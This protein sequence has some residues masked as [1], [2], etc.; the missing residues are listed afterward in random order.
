MECIGCGS[1]IPEKRT[2][3]HARFCSNHCRELTDRA[4]YQKKN[5][6]KTEV[7][8]G[9]RGAM[10]ELLVCA[11]LMGLGYEVF[12]NVSPH[13]SCDLAI[14]RDGKLMRVEVTTGVYT[15]SGK[16]FFPSKGQPG[17]KFDLL[18]VV[19]YGISGSSIDYY[20]DELLETNG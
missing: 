1:E 6:R 3:R 16:R 18:A 12:R 13:A 20:G 2:R 4:N 8:T 5:M 11:D 7:P 14:L 9:T 10:S 17:V 19:Y 15:A